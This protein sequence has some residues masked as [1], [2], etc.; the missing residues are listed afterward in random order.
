MRLDLAIL[1]VHEVIAIHTDP[2]EYRISKLE[3]QDY[4]T[5]PGCQ[6][7]RRNRVP[8]VTRRVECIVIFCRQ[9]GRAAK[10]YQDDIRSLCPDGGV[11][12]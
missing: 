12:G 2:W 5:R 7:S 1:L 4:Y 9:R 6:G 11:P 3:S 8:I 10:V